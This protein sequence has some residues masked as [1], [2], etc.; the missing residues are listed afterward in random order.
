M[1]ARNKPASEMHFHALMATVCVI[2]FLH[3]C[4]LAPVTYAAVKAMAAANR[5]QT[6][7]REAAAELEK[8]F[9]QNPASPAI[10]K[11]EA[12]KARME[13]GAK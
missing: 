6:A 3:L 9:Q 12:E 7:I 2:G 1:N 8:G 13:G 11:W 10:Q 5:A 4:L